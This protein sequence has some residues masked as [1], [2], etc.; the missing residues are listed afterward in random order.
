MNGYEVPH[1]KGNIMAGRYPINT[2]KEFIKMLKQ[3]KANASVNNIESPVISLAVAN[4]ASRPNRRGGV[5][6]KRANV[7]LEVKSGIMEKK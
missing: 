3:L 7:Y 2:S 4:R 1:R 5:R 6:A